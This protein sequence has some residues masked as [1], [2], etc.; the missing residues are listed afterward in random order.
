MVKALREG[1]H[2]TKERTEIHYQ[3]GAQF[4]QVIETR[5]NK[6]NMIYGEG[7]VAQATQ[8]ELFSS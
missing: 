4:T 7:K 8:K 6:L 5:L 1:Q 3:N 2:Q